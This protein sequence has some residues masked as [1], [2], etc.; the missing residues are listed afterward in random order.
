[1]DPNDIANELADSAMTDPGA[2]MDRD[3]EDAQSFEHQ[4]ALVAIRDIMTWVD[5]GGDVISIG[6]RATLVMECLGVREPPASLWSHWRQL[7]RH[8]QEASK[9]CG[10]LERWFGLRHPRR[11][12]FETK[13]KTNY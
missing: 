7:G 1:M 10:E 3:A 4:R 8:R 6:L 11:K 12:D 9:L 5:S 2:I 13:T